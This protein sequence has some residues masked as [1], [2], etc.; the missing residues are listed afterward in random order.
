MTVLPKK[1]T[2]QNMQQKTDINSLATLLKI[3]I[4]GDGAELF[5][6]SLPSPYIYSRTNAQHY[7]IEY[8]IDGV[9]WTAKSSAFLNDI[10]LR[11]NLSMHIEL[12]KTSIIS[13]LNQDTI[14]LKEF[15]SSSTLKSLSRITFQVRA[16]KYEDSVFW[17]LKLFVEHYIKKSHFIAYDTLFDF[18]QTHYYDHV[19][20]RS[21]LKAKCRSIWNWYYERDFQPSVYQRKY[22]DK[23]LKMSRQDHIKKVNENRKNATYKKVVN[24]ITGL[25]SD[26]YRKKNGAWHIS[27]IAK[28]LKINRKTVSKYIKE[29]AKQNNM[30]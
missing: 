21:T 26:E 3:E 11:F 29:Y 25:M 8:L 10:L 18:A 5:D 16:N 17:G 24:A 23:E 20:D 4:Q 22:T 27:S 1:D 15:S 7:T 28:D 9:F 6:Y 12:I 2:I 30:I 14:S 19:K 13:K